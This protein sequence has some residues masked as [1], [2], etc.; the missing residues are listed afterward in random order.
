MTTCWFCFP[1][2]SIEKNQGP[3]CFKNRYNWGIRHRPFILKLHQVKEAPIKLPIT[4]LVYNKVQ[5]GSNCWFHERT[6]WLSC[7]QSVVGRRES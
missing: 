6:M 2:P 7:P 1:Y 3:P 4:V 5:R